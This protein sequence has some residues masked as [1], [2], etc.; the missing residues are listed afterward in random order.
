MEQISLLHFL[1]P[2]KIL[3]KYKVTTDWKQDSINVCMP[4]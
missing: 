4:R 1:N 2:Q 3:L